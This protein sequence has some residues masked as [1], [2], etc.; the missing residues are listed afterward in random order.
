MRIKICWLAIKL[1]LLSILTAIQLIRSVHTVW[2]EVA[3]RTV[4][5]QIKPFSASKHTF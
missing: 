5:W 3:Q 4:I 2:L 1:K